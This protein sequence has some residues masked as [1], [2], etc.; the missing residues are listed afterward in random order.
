MSIPDSADGS[1]GDSPIRLALCITE[2]EIGGAERSLVELATRLD[3]REFAPVVYALGPRPRGQQAALVERLENSGIPV[4]FLNA[5]SPLQAPLVLYRLVAL[6]RAQR[7]DILQSFLVHANGLGTLAARLAGVPT[8]LTGIRVAER[9]SRWHL[10]LARLV[11][12]WVSRHVC[13]SQAVADFSATT[14]RLER[15][16][17]V[18]ISNGVDSSRHTPCAVAGVGKDVQTGVGN[19]HNHST[20]FQPVGCGTRSVPTTIG[21]SILFVGRLDAQKGADLLVDLAPQFLAQLPEHNLLMVGRGP[22]EAQLAAAVSRTPFADRIHLLGWRSDVAEI[23]AAAELVVLPSRWEGMSN[24]LLE[25][26]AAG[27]PV[28]ARDVEGVREAIGPD[29]A[30]QVVGSDPQAFTDKVVAIAGCPPARSRLGAA[31]Q[32]RVAREFT[33]E[34][35]VGQYAALYRELAGRSSAARL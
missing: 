26:M 33:L 11:D 21:R 3:R 5:T 10:V 6:L 29:G 22:L 35:M 8:I 20:N 1:T 15:A 14:G 4:H 12:R 9:R 16:R 32:Q 30:E 31:N 27:K 13:V 19:S 23:I 25:A 28:V 18:V 34:A 2:L 17:L 24:V 7:P